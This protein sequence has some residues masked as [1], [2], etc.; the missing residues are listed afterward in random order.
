MAQATLKGN[1]FQTT[2]ELPGVGSAAPAFTL[3][4]VDLSDQTLE[5]LAGKNV[6]LNIFP[7]VDTDVCAM[8]VRPFN[9]GASSLDNTVVLCAS[10]DVPFALAALK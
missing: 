9:S 8:S 6:V 7:S 5:Q 4:K 3:T 10:M 2:G 1:P